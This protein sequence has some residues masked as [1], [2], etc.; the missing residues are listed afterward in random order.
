MA[1]PIEGIASLGGCGQINIDF[2]VR[3]AHMA[4]TRRWMSI[5]VAVSRGYR[6][7]GKEAGSG[8]KAFI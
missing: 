2:K 1:S 3:A 8:G 4:S 5:P 6:E 7:Q